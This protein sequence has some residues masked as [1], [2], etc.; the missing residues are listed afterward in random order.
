VPLD[1]PDR[2]KKELPR[3]SSS[4]GAC[5]LLGEVDTG[6]STF[7]AVLANAAFE[8]GHKVAVVD[9]D[10]GQSDIGPPACV[11]F[12]ILREPLEHLEQVEPFGADFVGAT[13]PVGRLLQT[14]TA[15]AAMARAAEKAAAS[16]IVIDTTGFVHSEPARMLKAAKVALV[17][18][19]MIIAL[20]REDEVEHLLAPYNKRTRPAIM[21]LPV[22]RRVEKKTWDERK[23]RRERKFAQ[24]LAHGSA[25][26]VSLRSVAVE[27]SFYLTGS[28]LP[29]HWVS[30]LEEVLGCP[31]EYAERSDQATLAIVEEAAAHEMELVRRRANQADVVVRTSAEFRNLLVGLMDA[32]GAALDIGVVLNID[33]R[34]QTATIHTALDKGAKVTGLRLGYMR[35]ATDGREMAE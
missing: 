33:F 21:R 26:E 13:S 4:P 24:H 18:P 35:V 10:I 12:G 1:I 11:S 30:H 32:S 6:K 20:Q 16:F 9:A 25:L 23:A 3:L 17:D 5:L 29:G 7:C 28:A 31:V 19:L 27:G 15:T 2:W 22:S 14:A 34:A 8:A